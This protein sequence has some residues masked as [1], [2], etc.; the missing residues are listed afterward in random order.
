MTQTW[1]QKKYAELLPRFKAADFVRVVS[2]IDSPF[3]TMITLNRD[4]Y[5]ICA[6]TGK[7]FE[8]LYSGS[9]KDCIA[10]VFGF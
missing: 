5:H 2:S 4:V 8:V 6:V 1:S 9:Y 7:E 3:D 10:V